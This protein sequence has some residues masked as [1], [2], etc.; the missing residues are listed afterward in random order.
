M[1]EAGLARLREPRL[2]PR[3][4]KQRA[5]AWLLRRLLKK[6]LWRLLEK[7]W[8]RLLQEGITRERA[9]LK[10]LTGPSGCPRLKTGGECR[11][12]AKHFVRAS[13]SAGLRA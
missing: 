12:P 1:G 8:C 11:R 3:R 10:R 4:L 9:L 6:L 2:L 5:E 13:V 7:L